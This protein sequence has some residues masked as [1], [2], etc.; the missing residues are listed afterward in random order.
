MKMGEK[1]GED[2]GDDSV[3]LRAYL[4]WALSTTQVMQSTHGRAAVCYVGRLPDG[5]WQLAFA[6]DR[7]AGRRQR[8]FVSVTPSDV[9]RA[10]RWMLVKLAPGVWDIPTSIHVPGQFHGFTTLLNVPDPAPW[11][12]T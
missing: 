1:Q 8:H 12:T 7:D 2:P 9:A 10:D 4:L 5:E 11:E 3:I 6:I